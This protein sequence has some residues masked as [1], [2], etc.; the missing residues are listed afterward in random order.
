MIVERLSR[1]GLVLV[2]GRAGVGKSHLIEHEVAPRCVGRFLSTVPLVGLPQSQMEEFIR[3]YASKLH[4]PTL[5]VLDG[6]LDT[7]FLPE[8]LL[9]RGFELIVVSR[10]APV[11][12]RHV[13]KVVE[14]GPF[15]RGESVQFLTSNRRGL[16]A[17]EADRLAERLGDR[18][19][20]LTWSLRWLEPGVTVDRFLRK[21]RT[22]A[23]VMFAEQPGD[24]A[25]SLVAEVRRALDALP[26]S[27]LLSP[28]DLLGALALIDAVPFPVSGV[29]AQPSRLG[30]RSA[31]NELPQERRMPFYNLAGALRILEQH[32]LVRVT[33]GEASLVWLDCQL[34]RQVLS[35]AE[36]RRA[37]CL[38]ETMLLATVP[39]SGGVA[40]WEDWP[41]WE[42]SASAFNAIDPR[43]VETAAGRYALLASCDYLVER[44][45]AGEARDRLLE[46][47]SV[48]NRTKVVP[49]EFRLRAIDLLAQASFRIN[50]TTA[51]RHYAS[52]SYRTRKAVQGLL[53]P[54][55]LASTA[56]WAFVSG[57]IDRLTLL[58]PLAKDVPDQRLALR[59]SAFIAALRMRSFHDFCPVEEI[60]E[61]V[62]GQSDILGPE[63]P[64]TLVTADLLARAFSRA[65]EPEKAIAQYEKTLECRTRTLG[66]GHAHTTATSTAL[67]R[68]RR[69]LGREGL[70]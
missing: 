4:P 38:A 70:G 52:T 28:R 59:I 33:E 2:T 30:W 31:L 64:H 42:A 54:D 44:D 46:L 12:W 11:G 22:N 47:R 34:V 50:D 3:E 32:G 41:S 63:H 10:T 39:A 24:Q 65:G 25:P 9:R 37:A 5:L 69:E 8:A 67:Y 18:P 57:R 68:Q 19:R 7:E 43:F 16:T 29:E 45:R 1:D 62:R 35:P 21:A 53:H 27:G 23:H 20:A 14:V 58:R 66:P 56:H 60:E 13:A 26:H 48:W 17:E 40:L 36:T 49:W 61:I 51:A 15:S 6:V 55:T